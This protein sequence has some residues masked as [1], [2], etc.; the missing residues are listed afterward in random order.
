MPDSYNGKPVTAIGDRAFTDYYMVSITIPETITYI[1][2]NAFSTCYRIA[3]V[4]NYSSLDIVVGQDT[5]GKVASR[6]EQV[7]ISPDDS[8]L[9]IIDNSFIIYTDINDILLI[10]VITKDL[11]VVIP[12]II[13]DIRFDA[14]YENTRLQSI[15]VQ[16]GV[17]SIGQ[18]AFAACGC[19]G[20]VVIPRTVVS[21]DKYAFTQCLSLNSISFNGTIAEWN[22][23]TFGYNWHT[24][25]PTSIVNCADG[26]VYI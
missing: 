7:I 14:S 12:N 9:S 16:E 5:H 13:T 6:A 20:S 24:N 17:K 25:V 2:A 18:Y 11:N 19:L 3:E 1:G 23:I 26:E 8:K 21:V 22:S 4:I 15:V 10:S